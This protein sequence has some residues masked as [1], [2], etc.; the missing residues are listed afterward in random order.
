MG[1]NRNNMIDD[2]K[3][4]ENYFDDDVCKHF[5]IT[6]CPHGLFPNTRYDLGPCQKRHDNYFKL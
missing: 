1:K 4:N 3:T 6:I 5:L 2:E